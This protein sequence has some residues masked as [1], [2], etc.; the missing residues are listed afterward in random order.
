MAIRLENK[1]SISTFLNKIGILYPTLKYFVMFQSILYSITHTLSFAR[2]RSEKI[3]ICFSVF[4][5]LGVVGTA[6]A[7]LY[8]K[9]A[10]ESKAGNVYTFFKI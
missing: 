3:L 4:L 10:N 6:V 1:I 9:S 8:E 7:T 2:G 5:T